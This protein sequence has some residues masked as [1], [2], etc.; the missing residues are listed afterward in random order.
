MSELWVGLPHAAQIEHVIERANRLT[1]AEKEAI[2]RAL[3]RQ[4][5][6]TP[7]GVVDRLAAAFSAMRAMVRAHGSDSRSMRAVALSLPAQAQDVLLAVIAHDQVGLSEGWDQ[8]AY[9]LILEP[10][11]E[12]IGPVGYPATDDRAAF[13][14]F[15]DALETMMVVLFG[16]YP[17]TTEEAQAGLQRLKQFTTL[18]LLADIAGVLR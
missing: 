7:G 6:R 13:D 3:D 15:D 10:W 12:V 16:E 17:A 9:D 4:F 2:D 5:E 14:E 1:D 11:T 8:K 18:A